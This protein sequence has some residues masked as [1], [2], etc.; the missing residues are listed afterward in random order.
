M[1]NLRSLIFVWWSLQVR[2]PWRE[3]SRDWTLGSMDSMSMLWVT[4]PMAACPLVWILLSWFCFTCLFG[5]LY[6]YRSGI[7]FFWYHSDIVNE[8]S[9][10][11]IFSIWGYF[12]FRDHSGDCLMQGPWHLG[13]S[14]LVSIW[15]RIVLT[16]KY[17]WGHEHSLT[18]KYSPNIKFL[19]GIQL[20][21]PES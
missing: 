12:C 4:P 20:R 6:Q 1:C 10:F 19:L 21:Y 14:A 17:K 3:R 9:T 7:I 8:N 16:Q 5:R 2:P 15:F 13:R 18:L 11:L